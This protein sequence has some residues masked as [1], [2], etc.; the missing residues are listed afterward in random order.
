MRKVKIKK[1]REKRARIA[2]VSFIAINNCQAKLYCSITFNRVG[3]Q[4]RI[5]ATFTHLLVLILKP[6]VIE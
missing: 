3:K 4:L 6:L 2:S 5:C 1:N